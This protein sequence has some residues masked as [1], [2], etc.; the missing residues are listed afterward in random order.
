MEMVTVPPRLNVLLAGD[1]PAA[2]VICRH[3]SNRTAI[4][5]WNRKTDTFE[6]TQWLKGR[7]YPYRSDI[8]PDGKH[9][10]YFAMSEKNKT[11]SVLARVPYLKALDFYSKTDAWNGGGLF[12]SNGS[13]WLNEGG[14]SHR[15]E[16]QTSGLIVRDQWPDE[17]KRQWGEDPLIYFRRLK[18]DGWTDHGFT[19]VERF[20]GYQRFSKQCNHTYD[21]IK[22][23][24]CGTNHPIGKGPYYETHELYNRETKETTEYP[25]WEWADT[26][27]ERLLW[28][29]KGRICGC[30]ISRKTLGEAKELFDTTPLQFRL[31]E[32]PY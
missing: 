1:S 12:L 2:V 32:A 18:R 14:D 28:A 15:P 3:K 13:Y 5:G 17:G 10:V 20:D 31:M 26:D 16:R 24:H 27:R 11:Y 22:V 4:I 19:K 7:L 29:D 6:V 21:L 9:W 30:R 25:D 8:S 23:F